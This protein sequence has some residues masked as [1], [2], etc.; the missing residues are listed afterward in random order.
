MKWHFS[1]ET[2]SRFWLDR[3]ESLGFDP[4]ED[5]RS[6][7][8]L[9]RFRSVVDELRRV[10]VEDL[11]PRGYGSTAGLVGCFDS[12]GTTGAPK[13]VLL[14]DD[15][16]RLYGTWSMEYFDRHGVPRGV[17]WLG[18][19]PS[20]PHVVGAITGYQARARGGLKFDI[21]MDPRWVRTL[22]EG[23]RTED[24][25][26]YAG[27]LADQAVAVLQTQDVGVLVT[28]PPLLERLSRSDDVVDL[29][30]RKV[31]AIMW[32]GAHMDPDTRNLLRTEVFLGISLFGCYGSTMVLGASME[33][34]GLVSDDPCV[35]D[36]F[37]PH[38][39][40]SV[41]DAESR[42]P[43][44]FGERGRVLMHHV[45][46]SAFIPNNLERDFA[47]RVPSL[48]GIGDSVADITPVAAFDGKRVIE[49]VY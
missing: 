19:M 26:R 8:D 16:M 33:R 34:P 35:F 43:V 15:W 23:G 25:E 46:K 49:G 2:G 36:T 40:F 31:K 39:I 47:T 21:D 5:V 12:G 30:N 29:V 18:I 11:V 17:N 7:E 41:V 48:H 28:T 37:A 9:C 44:P 3:L 45:S 22:L 6:V 4:L 24:A 20:G 1:P 13:R 38:L 42:K 32:T 27:H 14:L 10:R